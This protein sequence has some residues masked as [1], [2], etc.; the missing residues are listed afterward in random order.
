MSTNIDLKVGGSAD[1]SMDASYTGESTSSSSCKWSGASSPHRT[2]SC[3]SYSLPSNPGGIS[4]IDSLTSA[5]QS[6]LTTALN[7]GQV[8]QITVEVD[9]FKNLQY[10]KTVLISTSNSAQASVTSTLSE[11]GYGASNQIHV[12]YPLTTI[13]ENIA[14][15]VDVGDMMEFVVR[16]NLEASGVPTPSS[17]DGRYSSYVKTTT[18]FGGGVITVG[19]S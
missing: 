19:M 5:H 9:I 12:T 11:A 14:I 4:N 13:S 8:S 1:F 15:S 16:V 6:Q 7:N 18:E 17:V 2:Y 3:R 10:V